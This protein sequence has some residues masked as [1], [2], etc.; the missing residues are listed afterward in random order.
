MVC[1]TVEIMHPSLDFNSRCITVK[2]PCGDQIGQT[3]DV[4]SDGNGISLTR[5]AEYA[6]QVDGAPEHEL[7][8]SKPG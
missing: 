7:L 8:C 3:L 2:Q 5:H 6:A 4:K 1:R